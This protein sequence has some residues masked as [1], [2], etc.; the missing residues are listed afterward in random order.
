MERGRTVS[1]RLGGRVVVEPYLNG[2]RQVCVDYADEVPS[3]LPVG[4]RWSASLEGAV[5]PYGWQVAYRVQKQ[6]VESTHPIGLRERYRLAG[7]GVELALGYSPVILVLR[8]VSSRD[9]WLRWDEW[10]NREEARRG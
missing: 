10:R 2:G 9:W 3:D 7:D 8:P 6:Y 4:Y 5:Y 1:G